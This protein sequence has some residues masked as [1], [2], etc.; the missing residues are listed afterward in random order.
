MVDKSS[1]GKTARAV[2]VL[3]VAAVVP[4]CAQTFTTLVN[5]TAAN[6][7]PNNNAPLIQGKDGNLYGTTVGSPG[8]YGGTVFKLTL[9][10]TLTT[11]SSLPFA[12]GY[13]PNGLEGGVIQGTDLNFY[14]TSYYG[15][16]GSGGTVFKVTPSGT[17]T[18]LCSF[19]ATTTYSYNPEGGLVQGADGNFY[20]TTP[21]NPGDDDG[22]LFVCTPGGTLTTL[23]TGNFGPNGRLVQAT[24]GNLYGSTVDGGAKGYGTVFKISPAGTLTTIYS[25]GSASTDGRGP[26]GWLVQASDGNLYGLTTSGPRDAG[27][28]FEVTLGGTLTTLHT[29]VANTEGL[30]GSSG[31]IQATDGNFYGT[32]DG[33][34]GPSNGGTIFKITSAGTLTTLYSFSPAD[35]LSSAGLLQA[36]DGNLYGTTQQ[37]SGTIY[38]LTLPAASIP[39]PTISSGGVV[40]ANSSSNTIQPGEWVSIYGTNLASVTQTWA[41]NFPISLGDTS[42]TID[43][44]AA[45]LSLVSPG[46]VNLQA[47][48]DT[49]TGSVSVTVT[50]ASGSVTSTVTLAQYAP[51]FFL[52]DTKH[53]AGII[54]RSDGSGAYDGGAYDIIGPTG[55]SLGYPTVAAK[56]GDFVELFGTGFGPTDPV[57]PAGQAFSGAAPA[58]SP[59]MLLI[60]N[61]SV[62]PSFAGLSGAGLVQINLTVPAGLGTGR[63]PTPG[64]CGWCANTVGCRDFPAVEVFDQSLAIVRSGHSPVARRWCSSVMSLKFTTYFAVGRTPS[65]APAFTAAGPPGPALAK[66][67]KAEADEGVVRGPGDRPTC[68][69][70]QC[71]SETG[72]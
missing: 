57:V 14:G 5:F 31:L 21:P 27:T 35:S 10:G 48:Q 38:K 18:T 67:L 49:A 47:P 45:Y 32:T 42:V 53:V 55:T 64:D 17:S 13:D 58:T 34:G 36:S 22:T 25:F 66:T 43:G 37:G 8:D 9:G 3:F 4:S 51:S 23:A 71:T 29:F 6:A 19:Q 70:L 56:A 20:G 69:L 68:L 12:Y 60:N 26:T 62:T 40:P 30:P 11:V 41:G 33:G 1:A 59:V 50:T 16:T 52:L 65:S 61:L 44:K 54:I 46:Q 7:G 28:F 2:F 15:G 63:C 24:D 39:A 72:H